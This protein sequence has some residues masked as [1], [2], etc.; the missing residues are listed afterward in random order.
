ML[1]FAN[2]NIMEEIIK[3]KSNGCG[4]CKALQPVIE[5]IAK[6]Y[7]DIKFSD[8]N[9]DDDPDKAAAFGVTTLPTLVFLKDGAEVGKLMGL[10]PKTLIVKKIAEVF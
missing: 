9:I 6:E 1:K 4:G 8:V 5:Q 10:K 3:F 2:N 7:P